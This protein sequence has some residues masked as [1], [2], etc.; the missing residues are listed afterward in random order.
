LP[1]LYG[2]D[3]SPSRNNARTH[4]VALFDSIGRGS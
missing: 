4:Y 2:A 3:H 1:Q